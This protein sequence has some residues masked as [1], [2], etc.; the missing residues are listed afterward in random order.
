MPRGLPTLSVERGRRMKE[1][2]CEGRGE[3]GRFCDKF[4][5]LINKY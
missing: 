2:L 5:K 4:L 1:G 3:E